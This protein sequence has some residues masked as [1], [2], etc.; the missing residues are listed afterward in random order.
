LRD[1]I[2]FHGLNGAK[3]DAARALASEIERL[4]SAKYNAGRFEE[5]GELLIPIERSPEVRV[6]GAGESGGLNSAQDHN[7]GRNL[8]AKKPLR[9]LNIDSVIGVDDD[10]D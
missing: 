2:D 7:F 5:N 4:A 8:V 10:R 3:L 1:L 9:H 6:S